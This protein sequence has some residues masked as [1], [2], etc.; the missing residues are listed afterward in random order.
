MLGIKA[1]E[2]RLVSQQDRAMIERPD[3]PRSKFT[4][5][6]TRKMTFDQQYLVPF[7]VDEILPGDHMR[8]DV[9]AFVRMATALFP[10]MDNLRLDTFFFF[11]PNRLVWANWVKFMGEQQ[12]PVSSIAYTVPQVTALTVAGFAVGGIADQFGIP[13]SIQTDGV[14]LPSVNA[15]PFR[16][17]NLIWNTWFRDENLQDSRNAVTTD[18][19]D[20]ESSYS[21]LNRGKSH[22]YFTSALPW[23]QKFTSAPVFSGGLAPVQGIGTIANALGTQTAF[24]QTTGLVLPNNTARV[25]TVF[26]PAG[27]TIGISQQASGNP[28]IYADLTNA[29]GMSINVLRQSFMI[30]V[31]L[32]RDAR[33]GSRYTEIVRQHFG[34]TSPDARLQRPEYL[35]G[36]SSAVILTPIAQTSPTAGVPL[37]ALGAAATAAGSHGASYAA[38]E[39][40][41]ILG[42]LSVK[43]ELSYGQGLWK[44]WSRLTRYDFYFPALA[45]MGEQA[46]LRKE[47][48]WRGD[49]TLDNTVFGYQERWHEYRTRVSEVT[50]LFRS[51]VDAAGALETWHLAQRFI[52]APVLGNAFIADVA[53]M[54]RVL[55]AGTAA[56]GQQFL[57][58]FLIKREAVRPLPMY[59]TPAIL[60]RF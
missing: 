17:L 45:G 32:E 6:W 36:G 41:Y 48:Y 18:G 39:H 46:I 56:D 13:T 27:G 24:Y 33:G 5:S 44:M 11:V 16:A 59:G 23:P 53:P 57:G 21:L 14:T 15:L 9:T 20:S 34:V 51:G 7:M 10:V 50:G 52:T 19:P 58:D 26:D 49:V 42:L 2:R 1:P 30:Q 55:A 60:G 22:D 38:T 12:D 47:I 35:G 43:S 37:G 29:T 28:A 8:Y 40:G 54:S 31:L 4:G 3:I 25:G